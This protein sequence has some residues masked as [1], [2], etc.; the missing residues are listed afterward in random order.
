MTLEDAFLL[1]TNDQVAPKHLIDRGNACCACC[2]CCRD[3]EGDEEAEEARPCCCP[4]GGLEDEFTVTFVAAPFGLVF[5]PGDG[6]G[7]VLV[8]PVPAVAIAVGVRVGHE[9]LRI[10]DL[11]VHSLPRAEIIVHI[12]NAE[13][14]CNAENPVVMTFGGDLG[15]G[16]EGDWVGEGDEGDSGSSDGGAAG[17]GGVIDIA[18]AIGESAKKDAGADNLSR[19]GSRSSGSQRSYYSHILPDG[20]QMV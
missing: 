2:C 16:D 1:L 18:H 7:A 15:E 19:G 13:L 11:D 8:D 4:G 6:L 5:E 17:G 3:G 10:G 9:I 14:G 20:D 12:A